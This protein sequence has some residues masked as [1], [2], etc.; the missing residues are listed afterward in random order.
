MRLDATRRELRAEIDACGYFPELVEDAIRLALGN[1]ELLDFVVHHEPTFNHDEIHR[2]ITVLALTPTRL[3][4]GHTDDQPAEPP[5]SGTFAAS[6]TESVAAD[7][8]QQ[9]GD[10]PGRGA[11]AEL[12]QRRSA[13][14]RGVAHRRLGRGPPGRSRAGVLQRPAVRGRSRLHRHH[15]RRRSDRPDERGRRRSRTGSLG[16]SASAPPCSERPTYDPRRRERLRPRLCPPMVVPAYGV[17]TVAEVMPSIGARIGVPG[18]HEDV[19]GL[20]D[21]RRY[22]VVLVD[23][24]GWHAVRRS[25]RAAPYLASLLGDAT[26][27]PPGCPARRRRAWPASAPG[28]RPVSTASSG[29]RRGCRRPGRSSTR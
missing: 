7:E 13:L 28:C 23:G 9:R 29:T 26:R 20:P 6:S 16:W 19:L 18:C 12:S 15:G 10:D 27:S 17:S 25:L 4:V 3:I 11:A 1:E 21:A 5:Q 8:D 24:L 14:R 2:H 22:V